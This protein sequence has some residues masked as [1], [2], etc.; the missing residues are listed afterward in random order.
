MKARTWSKAVKES[1]NFRLFFLQNP[2]PIWWFLAK[3]TFFF[4]FLLH[5]LWALLVR[6]MMDGRET[7]H[8]EENEGETMMDGRDVD[9]N[10]R[11]NLNLSII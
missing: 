5:F 11:T 6:K 10:L 1:Q 4:F 3:S 9:F 8:R 7:F 2:I